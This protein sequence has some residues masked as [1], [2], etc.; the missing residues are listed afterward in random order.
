VRDRERVKKVDTERVRESYRKLERE[1]ERDKV[2]HKERELK[3]KITGNAVM[4]NLFCIMLY[5]PQAQNVWETLCYVF[6]DLS[7]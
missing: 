2:R 7:F 5:G 4:H 3:I 6:N 1:R